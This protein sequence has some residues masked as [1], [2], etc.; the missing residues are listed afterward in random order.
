MNDDLSDAALAASLEGDFGSRYAEVNGIRLHYV[1]GGEGTPLL[2]LG[3]WPQTW[4]Q[5]HKVMPTLARRY[6]VVAADLRGMGGTDKP[7]SGFDKKT[8]AG[9][10]HALVRHLG[11]EKVHVAGHDIG[12]M[13]AQSLAANYPEVVD[14][15]AL[16][17]VHH[18]DETMYGLTLLPQPDQ[19]VAGDNRAGNR[20]YLWWFAFNQVRGLPETLL[21]GRERA[22]LDTLFDYL[23]LDP[24]SIDDRDREIYARAYASPE[25]VRA[26]NAWYQAFM[27]D[28]ED[29]HQ[30]PPLA[31]PVLALGGD[32][33]NYPYLA[34]VLPAK[35][36]N[37]KVVEV[38]NSGHYLPEEQPDTIVELL[39]GFFD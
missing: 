21:A 34:A 15:V 18:P 14:K 16:L 30:H 12:A 32:H 5:F 7:D 23:L 1:T 28:I 27:R 8:M 9:D 4:W 39:T 11:H 25:A 13:V 17:D 2:L 31:A 24:T 33:S 38:A 3:G 37:V 35:G 22:F 26:G 6:R 20:T 36:A 29:E 19:H 10:I